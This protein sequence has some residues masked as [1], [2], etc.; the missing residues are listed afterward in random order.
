M[1]VLAVIAGMAGIKGHRAAQDDAKLGNG[2]VYPPLTAPDEEELRRGS[3]SPEPPPPTPSLAPDNL[4]FKEYDLPAVDEAVGK[5]DLVRRDVRVAAAPRRLGVLVTTVITNNGNEPAEYWVN[6]RVTDADGGAFD[7][8][9]SYPTET[10]KPGEQFR[11]EADRFRE[12]LRDGIPT[13]VHPR[14]EIT[15]IDRTPA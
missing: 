5:E 10:L 3:P 11:K 6:L 7:A 2:P 9:E 4:P 15:R 8:E 12:Y 13:P 14:I 1:L